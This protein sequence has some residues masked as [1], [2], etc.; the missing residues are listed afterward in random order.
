MSSLFNL[1]FNEV[2]ISILQFFISRHSIWIFFESN[3]SLLLL[4][5]FLELYLKILKL[6]VLYVIPDCSNTYTNFAVWF[7]L[8]APSV[9][10]T[11][12]PTFLVCFIN[13]KCK[14]FIWPGNFSVQM[15]TFVAWAVAEFKL[16]LVFAFPI[17][18]ETLPT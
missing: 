8:S 3:F 10:L 4:S 2:L 16:R 5:I 15:D 13:F 7:L 14:L 17:F 12:V 6:S 18:L 11:M 9:V 1:L